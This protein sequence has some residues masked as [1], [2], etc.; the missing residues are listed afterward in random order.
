M[1]VTE[2]AWQVKAQFRATHNLNWWGN[3][4]E[5]ARPHQ[6]LFTVKVCCARRMHA[7][8]RSTVPDLAE[9]RDIVWSITNNLSG[10][11]LPDEMP[12]ASCEGIADHVAALVDAALNE[13]FGGCAGVASVSVWEDDCT[14]V[15]R[16]YDV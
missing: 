9:V 7:L 11:Y 2:T 4:H 12:C 16:F 5:C 15:R 6:H 14:G 3:D 10:K 13:A 8:D 1:R